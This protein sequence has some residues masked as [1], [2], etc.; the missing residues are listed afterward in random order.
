[1][2]ESES[3]AGES[4]VEK[5][6]IALILALVDAMSFTQIEGGVASYDPAVTGEAN[7]VLD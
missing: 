5:L 3:W 6:I 7:Y 2:S 4:K 1:M